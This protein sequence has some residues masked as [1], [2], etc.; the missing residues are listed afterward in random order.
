MISLLGPLLSMFAPI[1]LKWVVQKFANDQADAAT[2]KMVLEFIQKMQ[3]AGAVKRVEW[4]E[5]MEAVN[6]EMDNYRG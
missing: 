4:A 5:N 1:V 2:K 6:Q 3:E